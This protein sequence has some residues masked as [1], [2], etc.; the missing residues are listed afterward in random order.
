FTL[1]PGDSRQ[2]IVQYKPNAIG[3]PNG[4]LTLITEDG[5]SVIVTLTGTP[6]PGERGFTLSQPQIISTICDSA[7]ADFIFKNIYCTPVSVDS[8]SLGAPFRLDPIGLP[9]NLA[10]DSSIILHVHFVP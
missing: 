3:A 5:T 7:E 9:A 8:M 4:K 1:D 6:K 10:S 2:M